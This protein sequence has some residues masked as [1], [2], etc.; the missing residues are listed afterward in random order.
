[1]SSSKKPSKKVESPGPNRRLVVDMF[2]S[3]DGVMQAPGAPDEDR[4]DGFRYG[5]WSAAYWDEAMDRVLGE[6][7]SKPQDLL[8]G[9]KTY[10]VFAA[11]WPTRDD[12][13]G[14]LLNGATKYVASRSK[15]KLDW[16]NSKLLPGDVAAAVRGLKGKSGPPIHVLGSGNLVQTL[17]KND[18]VDELELW[19]FPVV[20]G[21]GKRLFDEGAIPTAWKLM[22]SETSGT[23]VLMQHYERAGDIALGRPPG[24]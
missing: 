6:S 18:L 22:R 4:S 13:R 20:I 12:D 8:L 16:Q 5:G 21:S 24:T 7:M 17:L 14:A 15:E 2:V 3:I 19:V 1:M 10:D 23:G 9:R 11:Y